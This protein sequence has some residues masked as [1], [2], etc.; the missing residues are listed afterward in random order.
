M[1]HF[2]SL[3]AI[4]FHEFVAQ[5]L[6]KQITEVDADDFM[7]YSLTLRKTIACNGIR[8]TVKCI[9]YILTG[10]HAKTQDVGDLVA[11]WITRVSPLYKVCTAL[12]LNSK[13]FTVFLFL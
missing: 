10:K 6:G 11:K 3:V 7:W 12:H 2:R 9:M 13:C 1:T 8:D 4:I 5:V